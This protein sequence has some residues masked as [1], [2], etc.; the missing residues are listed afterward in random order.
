MIGKQIRLERIMNRETAVPSSSPWI[1][2]TPRPHPGPRGHAKVTGKVVNGGANAILMHKG[3][4]QAGTAAA[5][6]TSG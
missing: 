6:E 2:A 3:M 4:V 5:G 1:T